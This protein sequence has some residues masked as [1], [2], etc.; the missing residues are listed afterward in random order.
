VATNSPS[1]SGPYQRLGGKER[2]SFGTYMSTEEECSDVASI[3]QKPSELMSAVECFHAQKFKA[4]MDVQGDKRAVL[5]VTGSGNSRKQKTPIKA[6]VKEA[7]EDLVD[8]EENNVMIKM[9]VANPM[10][11]T[12]EIQAMTIYKPCQQNL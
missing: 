2:V 11:L 5:K 7:L 8:D 9:E 4:T 6:I 3:E 12:K 1:N 10:E